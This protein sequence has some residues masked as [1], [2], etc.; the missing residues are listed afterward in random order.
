MYVGGDAWSQTGGFIGGGKGAADFGCLL[1]LRKWIRRGGGGTG[2]S[3]G[4]RWVGNRMLVVGGGGGKAQRRRCY[5][6]GGGK[7]GGLRAGSG[8]ED[9]RQPQ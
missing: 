2:C 4:R 9:Q 3:A 1:W 8:A 7:G 5:G 6:G